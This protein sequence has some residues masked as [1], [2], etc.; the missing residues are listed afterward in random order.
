[1]YTTSLKSQYRNLITHIILSITKIFSTFCFSGPSTTSTSTTSTTSTTTTN[2]PT[3]RDVITQ[4]VTGSNV[5]SGNGDIDS[6][7]PSDTSM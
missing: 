2:G 6:P 7:L 4:Q 5:A 1:M 3:M